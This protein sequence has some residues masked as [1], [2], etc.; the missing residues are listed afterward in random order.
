VSP[1]QALEPCEENCAAVGVGE[2]EGFVGSTVTLPVSFEQGPDD[3]QTDEGNDDVAAIALTIGI[4]GT[5]EGT[6]LQFTAADCQDANGDGLIDGVQVGAPIA[7]TFRVVVENADCVNR[8]RCLCPGEGQTRDDFINM[9]VFGPRNLPEQGP[10]DIPVLPD[11]GTLISL[12]LQIA[13]SAPKP[14]VIPVHVFAEIDDAATVEKPQFAANLSIGDRSAIDQTADRPADRSRVSF[15]D[16]SVT[17][18]QRPVSD[19]AGDCD[20]DD[21]VAVNELITGVNIALGTMNLSQC[22]V[23]DAGENGSVEIDELV[24]GVNNSLNGCPEPGQ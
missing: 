2:V 9:V 18:L 23:F 12:R 21:D 14:G 4:P 8:D 24:T 3:Q 16:G 7:S 10:V 6:P 20:N 22:T 1:T 15:D 17:V 19:C 13:D 5:G 11:S